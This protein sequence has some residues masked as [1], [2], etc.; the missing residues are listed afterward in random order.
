MTLPKCA[1]FTL[2]AYCFVVVTQAFALTPLE[3]ANVVVNRDGGVVNDVVT[4]L[5]DDGRTYILASWSQSPRH[6]AI[7]RLYQSFAGGYLLIAN[8][9]NGGG[10]HVADLDLVDIDGDGLPD[11]YWTVDSSGNTLGQISFTVFSSRIG[12]PI[13]ARLTYAHGSPSSNVSFDDA[14]RDNPALL[15]YVESK[16]GVHPRFQSAS[17]E[18]FNPLDA[19]NAITAWR[20]NYSGFTDHLAY[21]VTLDPIEYVL[22]PDSF[23]GIASRGGLD[24]GGIRLFSA[25]KDAVYALDVERGVFW[26][27]FVPEHTYAWI[28][29]VDT[30]GP[31]FAFSESFARQEPTIYYDPAEHL[32]SWDLPPS[33]GGE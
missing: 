7:T 8:V 17:T 15:A 4:A 22:D 29:D 16:I 6:S 9:E 21:W 1:R 33:C 25:F 19:S 12:V 31:C 5:G 26:V 28:R 2:L 27:V 20:A 18:P 32:L 3:A 30:I 13:V 10:T 24:H 23:V 14:L 11:A